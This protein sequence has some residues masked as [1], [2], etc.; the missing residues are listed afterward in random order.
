V[1]SAPKGTVLLSQGTDIALKHVELVGTHVPGATVVDPRFGWDLADRHVD[2]G[3]FA[4]GHGLGSELGPTGIV[5]GTV[6]TLGQ[7]MSHGEHFGSA[8]STSQVDGF[9]SDVDSFGFHGCFE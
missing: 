7:F 5:Q 6:L 8:T 2:E 4:D 1:G 3:R 9:G